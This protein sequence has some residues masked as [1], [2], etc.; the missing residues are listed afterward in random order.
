MHEIKYGKVV[1]ILKT[2]FNRNTEQ[3]IENFNP[4]NKIFTLNKTTF[5]LKKN[6]LFALTNT[7]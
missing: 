4:A 3:R 6:Y 7:Y 2:I 5:P 1:T